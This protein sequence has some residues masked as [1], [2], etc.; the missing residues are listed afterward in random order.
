MVLSDSSNDDKNPITQMTDDSRLNTLQE[1][2]KERIYNQ[3]KF[4]TKQINMLYEKKENKLFRP[5]PIED[6]IIEM[7]P[8]LS[9]DIPPSEPEVDSE[10][11]TDNEGL[12]NADYDDE[13]TKEP[14]S[15]CTI[16]DM[17]L[18]KRCIKGYFCTFVD[19][20]KRKGKFYD[21]DDGIKKEIIYKNGSPISNLYIR[22]VLNKMRHHTDALVR[23]SASKGVIFWR[24]IL[25]YYAKPTGKARK[26]ACVKKFIEEAERLN[27]KYLTS[28]KY[29]SNTGSNRLS[30]LNQRAQYAIRTKKKIDPNVELITKC[31]KQQTNFTK[32]S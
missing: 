17:K 15:Q 26:I 20:M 29:S 25:N 9:F 27:S 19:L 13:M 14:Y 30:V 23:Y 31:I 6:I 4:D 1:P 10:H 12:V 7:D 5:Q 32:E 3:K 24:N 8:S 18:N 11:F 22:C 28:T 21:F 2:I 16:N